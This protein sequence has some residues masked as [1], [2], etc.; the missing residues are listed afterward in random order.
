MLIENGVVRVGVEIEVAAFETG[1]TYQM[2]ADELVNMGHMEGEAAD[3]QQYHQYKCRCELGCGLVKSGDVLVPQL[4]SMQYDASLPDT[5]AEFIVSPSLLIN[6]MEEMREIWDVVTRHAL[7]DNTATNRHGGPSSPS[8]HLHVS[9]TMP[10]PGGENNIE[11]RTYDGAMAPPGRQ[12]P[13]DDLLHAFSLFAPELIMLSDIAEFRRGLT[14]R[15]PTRNADGR[16]AGHH[17]FIQVKSFTPNHESYIEWRIFEAAYQDWDYFEASA[18]LAG[19]LTRAS[20]RPEVFAQLMATGYAA[21]PDENAVNK[22]TRAD[23]TGG[24]IALAS[25]TRLA[26]LR[27]IALAELHDDTY[28]QNVLRDHFNRMEATHVLR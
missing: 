20:V 6:G 27:Q 23:N 13:A 12:R 16:P 7:W 8:I 10:P 19:A 24:L 11:A 2:V 22:L 17:G 25:R 9:A 18:Y 14:F 21:P 4:V 3:W 28:G 5:G 1:Y 26:G 15:Q